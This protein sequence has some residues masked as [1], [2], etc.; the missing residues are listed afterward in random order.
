MRDKSTAVIRSTHVMACLFFKQPS[1][2]VKV[3][4]TCPVQI[5]FSVSLMKRIHT[6]YLFFCVTDVE[7]HPERIT[8][9]FKQLLH[10]I[11]R[12]VSQLTFVGNMNR[13]QDDTKYTS[14]EVQLNNEISTR[15][16]QWSGVVY[17]A[18]TSFHLSKL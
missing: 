16:Q 1:L 6:F 13:W 3:T 10:A 5:S 12:D 18:A 8:K 4:E 11:F 7:L 17:S 15:W 2:P 14:R 9:Y